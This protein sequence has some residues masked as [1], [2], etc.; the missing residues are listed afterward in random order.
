MQ[1]TI[2]EI[3]K[4]FRYA[5]DPE[6]GQTGRVLGLEIN[7]QVLEIAH[8]GITAT[9]ETRKHYMQMEKAIDEIVSKFG[10][11]PAQSEPITESGNQKDTI[12]KKAAASKDEKPKKKRGR[13][14]KA[15]AEDASKKEPGRPRKNPVQKED[16]DITLSSSETSS[17][18]PV[19]TEP[20]EDEV[21][22]HEPCKTCRKSRRNA[23]GEYPVCDTPM[24]E[25]GTSGIETCALWWERR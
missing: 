14:P 10:D 13:P 3:K 19:A 9:D 1:G 15:K 7:G 24:F 20:A 17:E 5:F 2:Q 12:P 25:K 23:E 22:Y 4:V 21:I 18:P 8:D 16:T 6:Y 11:K